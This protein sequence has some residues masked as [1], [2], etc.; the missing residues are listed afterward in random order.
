MEDG[1]AGNGTLKGNCA[2]NN[3]TCHRNGECK[4]KSGYYIYFTWY[5]GLVFI[6]VYDKINYIL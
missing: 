3:E 4:R 1:R 2:G 5:I 6:H